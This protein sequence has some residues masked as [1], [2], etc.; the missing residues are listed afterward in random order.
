MNMATALRTAQTLRKSARTQ[1][2][3]EALRPPLRRGNLSPE[4]LVRAGTLLHNELSRP[5]CPI[6]ALPVRLLG[7]CTTFWLAR[8]LVAEA[9]AR[10]G[11]VRMSEGEYDQVMQ[12]LWQHPPEGSGPSVAIFLPWNQRLLGKQDRSYRQR[13]DEE[14]AFW[15]Q[16]WEIAAGSH[17]LRILQVGYDLMI[18]GP[19]GYHVGGQREGELA[20]I[21]EMNTVL[22]ASLPEN[23][24]FLDLGQVAADQGR[25]AFYDPRRYFWTKQPFSEAGACRL[26]QHLWAG[27]RALT[28][29]PK[30]VL[31]VDLDNTLW[32]GV[33]GELGPLGISLGESPDGEAFRAFQG[34]LAGLSK[35]GVVLAAC[36]KNNPADAKEPFFKNPNMVLKLEDFAAFEASWSPK[37]EGIARIADQLG[38]AV[39]SFVFF[40]DNP[41]EREQVRQACPQVEVV[42]VPEEPAAYVPALQ[43]GLW[44]EAPAVTA[45][46]K[47]RARHYREESQRRE[48]KTNYSS[49]EEYLTSLQ[50]RARAESVSEGNLHR[51]VQLLART[52]QFNLTTRRHTLEDVRRLLATP[53]AIGLTLTMEDRFGDYGLVG[54]MLGVPLA[55]APARIVRI[56]TFLLSCRVIGRTAEHFFLNC[57]LAQAKQLGYEQVQGQYQ[58][59]DKNVLVARLYEDLGFQPVS[60]GS[61]DAR[62]FVLNLAEAS[63][64]ATFVSAPR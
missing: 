9:W 22:R 62:R 37:A 34:H 61:A 13:I 63:A 10:N 50:M 8:A 57:L 3:L 26:A 15:K 2:A 23:A 19:Q 53:G 51:V 52:N 49:L 44:F 32:G 46:D 21:Q 47:M 48:L 31:V 55:E 60:P 38:L 12:E 41:A 11:A 28:T 4:E 29:G 35:R 25:S 45:A 39:D 42:E 7:Q 30:K 16:A 18:V 14:L 64:R 54:V 24:F 36:T 6:P 43:H 5:D 17:G 20:L 59:T 27:V 56:D 58:P 33:V 1:E 40:D